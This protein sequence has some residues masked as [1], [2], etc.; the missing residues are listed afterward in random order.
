[1]R[2]DSH[3]DASSVI[4]RLH[5]RLAGWRLDLRLAGGAD[6][7]DD[8]LLACR[9]KQLVQPTL[10][11]VIAEGLRR[12]L[13]RAGTAPYGAAIPVAQASVEMYAEELLALAERLDGE[14]PVEARGVAR[15]RLLLVDGSSPLYRVASPLKLHIALDRALNGLEP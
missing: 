4:R 12:V 10:R 15:A 6:P 1:M 8:E 2:G 14:H 7:R 11:H 13:A 9:A 5:A 3:A